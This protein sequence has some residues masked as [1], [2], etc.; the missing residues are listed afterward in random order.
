MYAVCTNIGDNTLDLLCQTDRDMFLYFCLSHSPTGG[1]IKVTQITC[2]SKPLAQ[3]AVQ[4]VAYES[5]LL[6]VATL[7]N[8]S[9]ELV[10]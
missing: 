7:L 9:K 6:I 1:G 8:L 5:P 3:V 2:A 4:S 10:K